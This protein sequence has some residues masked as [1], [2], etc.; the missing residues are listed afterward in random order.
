MPDWTLFSNHGLVLV[1]IAKNPQ[2]TARDIGDEVGLTE[3]TTHKIIVDLEKEGYIERIKSGR[4]NTYRI[5]WGKQ[6]TDPVV[7][8]SIGELLIA[9]APGRRKRQTKAGTP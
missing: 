4:Q 3:R 6:I 7:D 1:A 9:L 8:A 5:H 2:R